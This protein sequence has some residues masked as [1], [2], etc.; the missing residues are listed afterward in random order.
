MRDEQLYVTGLGP[1]PVG[2]GLRSC[3]VEVQVVLSS[4]PCTGSVLVSQI[5]I[6]RTRP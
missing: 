3:G 1:D 2:V 5:K 6:N 4:E